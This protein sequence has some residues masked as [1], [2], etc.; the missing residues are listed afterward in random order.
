[1]LAKFIHLFRKK[2][3]GL[4]TEPAEPTEFELLE[5][6]LR[7]LQKRERRQAQLLEQMY[8]DL[9]GKLDRV[10]AQQSFELP[11]DEIAAC[12]ENL[13]LYSQH[14][15]QDEALAQIWKK[16]TL[17]LDALGMEL[18]LDH[19]QRFDDT[20]HQVCDIRNDPQAP[21]NAVLEVVRPGLVVHGQ[22]TR[23]AV[24]VVNRNATP[25]N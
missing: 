2:P 5:D 10:L 4:D 25:A 8:Q 21:E 24:V 13:A 18:I 6:R 17:M 12:A 7:K 19:H 11:I 20:R 22:I 15:P 16:F 9:G 23:P 3:S 1:M 14:H